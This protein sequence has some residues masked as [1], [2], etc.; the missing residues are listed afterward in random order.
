LQSGEFLELDSFTQ[1]N[2]ELTRTL[3]GEAEGSV[4]ACIDQTVTAAG[5]R[6]LFLHLSSPLCVVEK[7][8]E[9]LEGVEF[10]TNN[11]TVLE[12]LR[13]TLKSCP[14]LERPFSRLITGRGSP[15][16]LGAIKAGLACVPEIQKL[17]SPFRA[18]ENLPPYLQHCLR[19]LGDHTGLVNLLERALARELPSLTRAGGFIAPGYDNELDDLCRLRDEG[20]ALIAQL[21]E[22]YIQETG[23]PNLKIRHNSIL[24]YTIEVSPSHL[25]KVPFH[26]THRQTL[27]NAVRYT[28]TALIF[29]SYVK[30]A[31]LQ[32]L[33][34]FRNYRTKKT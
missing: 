26:F 20:H 9:R 7:I 18:Q 19:A 5:S 32:K 17:F 27:S 21:Q 24:G 2:L 3:S 33:F 13:H 22:S 11:R 30:T 8:Q 28:T 29:C 15:R 1:R 6:L 10:F 31:K 34:S 12:N 14:D 23:I 16:D 25:S 4:L